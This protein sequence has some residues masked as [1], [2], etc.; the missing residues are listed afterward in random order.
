MPSFPP[1]HSF[2]YV[3]QHPKQILVFPLHL[4]VRQLQFDKLRGRSLRKRAIGFAIL[5][6]VLGA[7][8]ATSLIIG[9]LTPADRGNDL[10]NLPGNLLLAAMGCSFVFALA[11]YAASAES[12]RIS[13]T[14]SI[15]I[16]ATVV[17]IAFLI[18]TPNPRNKMPDPKAWLATTTPIVAGL[19]ICAVLVFINCRGLPK[20]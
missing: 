5:I 2:R 6:V 12:P 7:V 8:L 18:G 1:V 4:P 11:G 14:R 16:I 13:Q 3:R 20:N 15:L 17:I 10:A 19:V 9:D